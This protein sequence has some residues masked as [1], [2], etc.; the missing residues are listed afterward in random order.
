MPRLILQILLLLVLAFTLTLGCKDTSPSAKSE[1]AQSKTIQAPGTSR[2]AAPQLTIL[3]VDD[4][5]L[6]AGLKLLRGEWAER[7]GGQLVLKQISVQELSNW[8]LADSKL[9]SDLIIY[10]S[11][12]VGSLVSKDWLRPVLK[13]VLQSEEVGI[14]DFYPLIRNVVLPYGEQIYALTLGEPP[15]MLVR[16]TES[17]SSVA[18]PTWRDVG[19]RL[20]TE[21]SPLRYPLA[22]E[23][24]VRGTAFAQYR[25][26]SPGWFDS[27]TMQA[28]IATP[29]Y[30]RA[31][32]QMLASKQAASQQAV[33]QE[34]AQTTDLTALSWPSASRENSLEPLSFSPLPRAAEVYNPLLKTWEAN[35]SEA[36]LVFLGY[37][38]RSVSVTRSTRNSSSAFKL[39]RWIASDSVA[40]QLSPRS[41][42]TAWFRRSQATKAKKWLPKR[43]SSAETAHAVT[44]LLSARRAHLLPRIPGIDTYLQSLDATIGHALGQGLPAESVLARAAEQ[45]DAL[46]G[47]LGRDR[48]LKAYRKHLGLSA[49]TKYPG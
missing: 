16:N 3:I 44:E 42:A 19:H 4:R 7:T 39:L 26:Q 2:Q 35:E 40:L 9:K 31:L 45:W 41:Q 49:L 1:L 14:G 13:S 11:R 24:L 22:I 25:G 12:F 43:G 33:S 8:P 17:R 21:L 27:G 20:N 32:E 36:T 15:L 6:T 23:L 38:G 46:T 37:A 18:L 47:K 29:P 48:Q 10:P 5:P 30:A 28:K 34:T